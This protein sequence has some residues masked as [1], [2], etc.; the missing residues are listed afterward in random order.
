MGSIEQTSLSGAEF[1]DDNE[2]GTMST[3][4]AMI[5]GGNSVTVTAAGGP[6]FGDSKDK[7]C[8]DLTNNMASISLEPQTGCIF[9]GVTVMGGSVNMTSGNPIVWSGADGVGMVYFMFNISC[10]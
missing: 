7:E 4:V 10:G 9:T 2:C 6:S 8:S 1:D 5:S 3:W